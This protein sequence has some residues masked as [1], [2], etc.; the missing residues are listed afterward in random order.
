MHGVWSSGSVCIFLSTL[1][2]RPLGKCSQT[3]GCSKVFN[4]S[5]YLYSSN[6]TVQLPL[7][8]WKILIIL[9]SLKDFTAFNSSS[10]HFYWWGFRNFDQER[11]TDFEPDC[12][13]KITGKEPV[14]YYLSEHSRNS[15]LAFISSVSIGF[16]PVWTHDLILF[17][18][19]PRTDFGMGPPLRRLEG[20]VCLW[21][22]WAEQ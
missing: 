10:I 9:L 17:F 11:R 14:F 7:S 3:P 18:P 6:N 12:S 5:L 15:L 2:V 13:T 21:L 19:W 22:L 8:T 16:G 1:A 20:L 4:I